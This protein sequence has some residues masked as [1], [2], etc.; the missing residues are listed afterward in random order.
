MPIITLKC[1]PFFVLTDKEEFSLEVYAVALN[2]LS[3]RPDKFDDVSKDL[4]V[5]ISTSL[6]Q[7]ATMNKVVDVLL[8]KVHKIYNI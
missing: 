8:E 1:F 3:H 7:L 6:K 5:K 4:L 2:V